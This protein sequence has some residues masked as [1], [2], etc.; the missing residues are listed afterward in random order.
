M[1]EAGGI[2]SHAEGCNSK[3]GAEFGNYA[4]AEGENT[5]AQGA[6][7]HAEGLNT[8]AGGT[9]AH[10]EGV[11]NE[12]NSA[13]ACHIEGVGNILDGNNASGITYGVHM[14]GKYSNIDAMYPYVDDGLRLIDVVGV[15]TSDS[16]RINGEALTT[17]GAL[18]VKDHVYGACNDDST[19]G[20]PLI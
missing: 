17:G 2:A 10:V 12:S 13:F 18:R 4:H 14:Q 9:A 5:F 1:T 6:R 16:N 3:T 7:S 19:G 15:G 8:V 20:E 11:N